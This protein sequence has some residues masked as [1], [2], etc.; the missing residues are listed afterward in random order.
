M[1]ERSGVRV[2]R[3]VV[4]ITICFQLLFFFLLLIPFLSLVQP[5]LKFTMVPFSHRGIKL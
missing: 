5:F 3:V 4:V 1:H 2:R